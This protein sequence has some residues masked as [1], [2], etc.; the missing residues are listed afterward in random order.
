MEEISVSDLVEAK[1]EYTKQLSNILKPN[2]LQGF[3]SLYEEAL[4]RKKESYDPVY[5]DFNDLQLFQ[6]L[7][8][9]IPKWNQNIIDREAKRIMENTQSEEYLGKL[10]TAVIIS[11]SRIMTC[12]KHNNLDLNDLKIPSI[13]SFIHRCYI[14]CAKEFYRNPYLFDID[15]SAI[16]KQRN[17][18]DKLI[19]IDNSIIEAIRRC[20]P[21][22][23]ILK[24]V[25]NPNMQQLNLTTNENT[26]TNDTSFSQLF[27]KEPGV[28][29][30]KEYMKKGIVPTKTEEQMIDDIIND[31]DEESINSKTNSVKNDNRDMISIKN[32]NRDMISMKN[33]NRDMISMKN[34]NRDMISIKNDNRD[35]ISMKND[36]RDMIS[37]NSVKSDSKILSKEMVNHINNPVKNTRR[38]LKWQQMREKIRRNR[39]KQKEKFK[40]FDE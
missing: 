29:T 34:D 7:I 15:C 5:A 17:L 18:K 2:I 16:E 24:N 20:L 30:N 31:S 13:Q 39:N 19:S 37:M 23:D 27:L 22:K 40:F 8:R 32:D 38:K 9:E 1:Y 26:I 11:H 25:I 3:N 10:I 35:M 14:E 28:A 21:V 33:D 4:K 12:I 6:S 36:N